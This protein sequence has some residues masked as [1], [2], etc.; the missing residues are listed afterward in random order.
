MKKLLSILMCLML[1]CSVAAAETTLSGGETRNIQ[2]HPAG[3]NTP[4]DGVSPTTGRLLADVAENAQD[5]FTGMAVTGRYMPILMQIDNTDGGI[6]Y[7]DGKATGYRAP[8]GAQ[9]AD[10]IYEAPL[11]KAGDTRLTFL[12]SDLMPTAAGPCRSARLFHAWLREEYDGALIHYGQQELAGTN[13]VEAFKETGANKKANGMLLFNGT[14]GMGKSHPWKQYFSPYTLKNGAA[15]TPPH[16]QSANVAAMSTL[17]PADYQA[18]N[19]TW[20]FTD[21]LPAEGDSAEMIHVNWSTGDNSVYNSILEWDEDNACYYRY[22]T[23]AKGNPQLYSSLND[24]DPAEPITF[25][26][27]IV[28]FTEMDWVKTN[29]P[30]PTVLGTGNADYF[31]G[32]KHIAGVW[33]RDSLSD[34]TVF[35]GPDGNEI[36]LQRGRTLII[37]M[38]YQFDYR[39]VSFE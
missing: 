10:V 15:L 35:Y 2:I 5:G 36:E 8:W 19:H 32:G 7:N 34:R 29:Q 22:M 26:N 17:I 33:G 20:L 39:S 18:A 16:H 23:D 27:V 31:M 21:E 28:Q 30:K 6:G 4:I 38:D 11:Y 37:V 14:D 9:Y 25:S 1:L 3:V 13:V 12:F 24:V